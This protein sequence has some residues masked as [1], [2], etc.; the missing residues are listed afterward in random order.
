MFR[1]RMIGA[2]SS[3][4]ARR[5]SRRRAGCAAALLRRNRGRTQGTALG[6]GL[7]CLASVLPGAVGADTPDAAELVRSAV[8][9]WRGDSSYIRVDM[10]VHRPEWERSLSMI[11]WTRGRQD[12]LIRFTAPPKDAG[13]A[14]LKLEQSMW[15]FTPKLNQVIKLP[16]S[17]MAQSW[18]GSDFSYND[19]AKSDRI[20]SDYTHALVATEAANGHTEYTIESIP[21]PGA[22]VVWGKQRLKIRDDYVMLEES[23]Y[24]QDMALVKQLETTEIGPL[25]GRPYSVRMRMTS[26]DEDD[27]WTELHY[28]EGVFDLTLPDYLFTLSNLR[29]PRSWTPP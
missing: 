7:S 25:G 3:C 6:F 27:E 5:G 15:I 24:D 2:S 26:F 29:N 10:T 20:I 17:M 9:Y 13:N 14:T 11:G 8:D 22:P 4:P 12:A 28:S 19:L 18:M 23:Y 21:K 1:Q 16:A